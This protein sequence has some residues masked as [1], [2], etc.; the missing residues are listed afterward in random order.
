[1]P[2]SGGT[3]DTK[4]NTLKK[5]SEKMTFREFIISENQF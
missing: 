5:V 1:M 2:G 3:P 4:K